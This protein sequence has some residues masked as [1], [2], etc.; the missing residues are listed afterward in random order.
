M[1]K[2]MLFY[3]IFKKLCSL[4]DTDES[5]ESFEAG[6]DQLD[7]WVD[8]DLARSNA[9]CARCQAIINGIIKHSKD[10]TN[11]AAVKYSVSKGCNYVFGFWSTLKCKV[12]ILFNKSKIAGKILHHKNALNTCQSLRSC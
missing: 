5:S 9:N 3:S 8:Q 7:N 1:F 11:E 4:C 12:W 2:Y 6:Q 10:V